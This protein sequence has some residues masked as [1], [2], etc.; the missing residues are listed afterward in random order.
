MCLRYKKAIKSTNHLT[1]HVNACKILV[2]LPSRLFLKL[3][4]AL[5]YNNIFHYLNVSSDNKKENFGLANIYK[6]KPATPLDF[7]S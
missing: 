5:E 3:E 7:K 6:Q 4:Q 2:A 1:R